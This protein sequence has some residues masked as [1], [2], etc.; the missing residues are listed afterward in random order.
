[1]S[2]GGRTS[3]PCYSG[4]PVVVVVLVST[5]LAIS[6][7]LTPHFPRLLDVSAANDADG[8]DEACAESGVCVADG[9]GGVDDD[10]VVVVVPPD[11]DIVVDGVTGGGGDDAMPRMHAANGDRLITHEEL[12]LHTTTDE[13]I[14]L[15]I[16]GKVYDVTEGEDYYGALKGGYKFYAGR[17]ASPCFATGQNTPEGAVEDMGAWE[18]KKQLGVYEWAIFYEKHEKYK[19]LGILADSLYYDAD[20]NETEFRRDMVER[21]SEAKKIA[22]AEKERKKAERLA[23]REARKLKIK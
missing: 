23:A 7:N 2:W 4:G 5:M 11:G 19:Y 18:T 6:S 3:A 10:V 12:S 22:D 21:C 16:L 14:W 17:D 20:G 15:S 1:M 8:A 13:R 9:E